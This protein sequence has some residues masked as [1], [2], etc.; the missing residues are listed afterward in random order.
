MPM[1]AG[2]FSMGIGFPC[3]WK[4]YWGPTELFKNAYSIATFLDFHAK[5]LGFLNLSELSS[6]IFYSFFCDQLEAK[7]ID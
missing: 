1:T 2:I 7:N 3:Y 6:G 4:E 5:A